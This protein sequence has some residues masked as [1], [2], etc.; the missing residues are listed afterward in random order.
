MIEIRHFLQYTLDRNFLVVAYLPTARLI[1]IRY[2]CEAVAPLILFGKR[3]TPELVGTRKRN[4]WAFLPFEH[5]YAVNAAAIRRVREADREL[6]R[7][8]FCLPNALGH[9]LVPSLRFN[10]CE[11]V[12]AVLKHIVCL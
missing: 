3:P 10:N 11:L 12:I 5:V 8:I 9:L 2:C 4:N 7:V 6:A 1:G